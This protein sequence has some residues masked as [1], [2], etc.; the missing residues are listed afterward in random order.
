MVSIWWFPFAFQE[1]E[2]AE[3]DDEG[4]NEWNKARVL[5]RTDRCLNK[6]V[7]TLGAVGESIVTLLELVV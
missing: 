5:E 7:G 3:S 1:S 4:N 6:P 2:S